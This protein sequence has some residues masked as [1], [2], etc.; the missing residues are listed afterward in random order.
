MAI[1]RLRRPH[2]LDEDTILVHVSTYYFDYADETID[3]DLYP[4]EDSHWGGRERSLINGQLLEDYSI[5]NKE[6]VWLLENSIENY[7]IKRFNVAKS[8]SEYEKRYE[9][10]LK[11]PAMMATIWKLKFSRSKGL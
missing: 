4:I 3:E 6:R 10:Y 1:V 5:K 9:V 7:H 8:T 2:N 11:L